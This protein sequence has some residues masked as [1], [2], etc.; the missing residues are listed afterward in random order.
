MSLLIQY[1][2]NEESVSIG[3]D[4][5]GSLDMINTGVTTIS[6][7]FESISI[8]A[9]HFDGSSHLN[10]PSASLPAS[11][12]GSSSRTF[13]CWVKPTDATSNNTIHYNGTNGAVF[14]RYRG[15]IRNDETIR[16]D[17]NN[18]ANTT[19]TSLTPNTWHHYSST[20]DGSTSIIYIDGVSASSISVGLNTSTSD[21]LFIG[22]ANPGEYLNG[23]LSDFRFYDGA[24]DATAVSDIYAAGPLD[25]NLFS[26]TMYT[27]V[28]DISWGAVSGATTYTLTEKKDAEDDVVIADAISETNFTSYN[29]NPGSSYEYNLFTDLDLVTPES[30]IIDTAP[31]VNTTSV[32]DLLT[33]LSNDLSIL[34]SNSIDDIE[35]ELRNI[36][37]TGDEVVL[38]NST[39]TQN[40]VFVQQA[41]TLELVPGKSILTP[42]D[43]SLSSGSITVTTADLDS[44][45]IT[46]DETLNELTFDGATTLGVGDY[47]TLGKYKVTVKEI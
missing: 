27:N 2:F 43:S 15:G 30:T 28:A 8:N 29:L 39:G 46:Y 22:Q 4:S 47:T 20:Y 45:A 37:D 18:A 35:L 16:M 21:D 41:D 13:S 26:V 1:R 7:T 34:N 24:L 17:F 25:V 19:T 33:R 40:S 36:L 6:E 44:T 5:V 38:R 3:T 11:M 12:T 10:L 42:F 31:S 14:Q 23:S 9:A 32:N